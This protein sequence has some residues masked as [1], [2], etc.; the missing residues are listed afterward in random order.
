[1]ISKEKILD[2]W[3]MVEHLSE[4]D[5][6]KNDKSM[7]RFDSVSDENFYGF[8]KQSLDKALIER[9]IFSKSGGLVIYLDIFDFNEVIKMIRKWYK[10]EP[11]EEDIRVGEKF[12][13]AIYFDSK[14]N[15]LSEMTFCTISGYIY[16]Q[17]SKDIQKDTMGF[18]NKFH[19]FETDFKLQ[20]QQDFDGSAEDSEKF[21]AAMKKLLSCFSVSESRFKLL[22]NV[23]TDGTNLH[24]F[25]ISD[26][27][28]AKNI[29]TDNL[30]S[31][32]YGYAGQKVNL[33]S[34]SDSVNYNPDIFSKILQPSQYPSGR[35]PG[36]TKFALS[37][38]QQA[39]VNLSLGFD[40]R[41]IRSVNGPPGTGKTTLLKDI[42]AELIV[43]QAVGIVDMKERCI[44]GTE[45]TVY[46]NSASIGE[47]PDVIS[48]NGIV[49]ASS[50]NGAV[51]NIVNEL[52]LISKIDSKMTDGLKNDD[53]YFWKLSNSDISVE[54]KK[55]ESGKPQ[56][57]IVCKEREGED[58][59]WGLFSLEGGRAENMT[60]IITKIECICR[61][62]N[63]EYISDDDV[64]WD[65]R[66]K[67]DAVSK[68]KANVQRFAESH[69]K[70]RQERIDIRRYKNSYLLQRKQKEKNISE[71]CRELEQSVIQCDRQINAVKKKYQE[72]EIQRGNS[73]N[74]VNQYNNILESLKMTKP[75]L[76]ERFKR[77]QYND[78][79]NKA[80]EQL[81]QAI[82]ED[83]N[84]YREQYGVKK[85]LD[86]LE[87]ERN[88]L[89]EQSRNKKQDLAE[90]IS[91]A[92]NKIANLEKSIADFEKSEC[93]F[94]PLDM[95]LDY[96]TLQLSNP[97]FD[98]DFRIAQSE[99]FLSALR[100]RKQF[101][102]ENRKNIKA[103][104]IIWSSQK[105]YLENKR[106]IAAAWHWINFT[107][108]II[109]STF[110]SFSRMCQNIGENTLGH[111]F[112]DEAGQALPQAAIGAIFRSRNV[113]VVGDPAQIKPVLTLDAHILSMIARHFGVTEKYLSDS[114]SAQT[115]VDSASRFGF[116]REQDRSEDS[117]IGIP[118]WVHRRCMYPMFTISNKI[119]YNDMM[120]QGTKKYG[121][122]GWFDVSGQADNKF[123][124]EQAE[125]LQ[126]RLLKMMKNNPKAKDNIYVI[127]PFANVAQRLAQTLDKIGFTK[128]DN[129]R[130]PVNI[131]TVH[132]F[133]GK[134]APVVFMVLGA[135]RQSKGAAGWAVGEPNMMNVAA[136]RAK[137]EFY[138]IGDRELYRSL[139]SEVANNT[140]AVIQR[141]GKEHPE[142][143]DNDISDIK[144]E[145][146][147]SPP[148]SKADTSDKQPERIVGQVLNVNTNRSTNR[149]YAYVKGNNGIRYTITEQIYSETKNAD[150]II[151]QGRYITFVAKSNQTNTVRYAC[152]I[153]KFQS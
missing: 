73:Q 108:P 45:E 125:F 6:N 118:L 113:M 78:D 44:A 70:Y 98:E 63:E 15:F 130:K 38:M 80:R 91:S 143:V 89:I 1:M 136:T 29:H 13:A 151:C 66:T 61:Y 86:K 52:P 95:G 83:D 14:L 58:K 33:D 30:Q 24:S 59:F 51:Q 41:K 77:K 26:L 100:V 46:F 116:Y 32:L 148:K 128:R 101:L 115:L 47:L 104:C 144:S 8:F 56:K 142:L 75:S 139:G 43:R 20:L 19:E 67:Y 105:K 127:T 126:K 131:G 84:I 72:F 140:M 82:Y 9:K 111:L 64:Y 27:E 23:E 106:L 40:E 103:A 79:M 39:V 17:N 135:D 3:I 16:M 149:K 42:F 49:V 85:Q 121:K 34:K 117:W 81:Q 37:F 133:Q 132:T 18:E 152:N 96:E 88:S 21:N 97:W 92:E 2:S 28:K 122:T 71:Q 53:G 147:I 4:G 10:L 153:E 48:E 65:F 57:T 138:V 12:K 11:T 31:Y 107:I 129:N 150:S 93:R 68:M 141:Y 35:F 124:R 102:Y 134:E 99:L 110:A 50:N 36:E 94:Q 123:V 25:F 69:L 114:A 22:K 119:S 5:I 120:V 112:V 54:W 109:S 76:F 90:W 146:V 87:Q 55:D 74:K 60:N 62:L 145:T 137:E 7:F